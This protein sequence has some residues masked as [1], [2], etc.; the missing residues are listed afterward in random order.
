M[1]HKERGKCMKGYVLAMVIVVSAV[2][3]LLG[4]SYAN[5]G[6]CDTSAMK[7]DEQSAPQGAANE[8]AGA[9]IVN[10]VCPVSGMAIAKD[11]PYKTTYEGKEVG[12]CSEA[13][14]EAFKA[15]PKKYADNIK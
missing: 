10:T 15:D 3:A 2:F 1:Y 12:F 5:C 9:A 13:C 11:T 4:V 6:T 14:V 8:A 7:S